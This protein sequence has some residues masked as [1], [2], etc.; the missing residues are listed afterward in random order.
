MVVYIDVSNIGSLVGTDPSTVTNSC[1]TGYSFNGLQLGT[2]VVRELP[3]S[4]T[5]PEPRPSAGRHRGDPHRLRRHRGRVGHH[6]GGRQH[7]HVPGRPA[8]R[9]APSSPR[10]WATRPCSPP[11]PWPTTPARLRRPSP[12]FDHRPAGHCGHVLLCSTGS[13]SGVRPTLPRLSPRTGQRRLPDKQQGRDHERRCGSNFV[14][15]T[16]SRSRSWKSRLSA[17]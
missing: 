6:Q 2:Y 15:L 17:G 11:A 3:P 8:S 7:M 4:G 14:T 13:D 5:V 10:P 16:A 12:L 1:R 9:G